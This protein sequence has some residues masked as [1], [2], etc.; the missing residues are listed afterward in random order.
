[1]VD[2]P[3]LITSLA[4][5]L[6]WPNIESASSL[7]LAYILSSSLDSGIDNIHSSLVEKYAFNWWDASKVRHL[8]V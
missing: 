3:P 2:I 8:V 4:K 1:M 6:F 7:D 5:H